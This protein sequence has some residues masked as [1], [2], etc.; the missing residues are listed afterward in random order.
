MQG[1]TTRKPNYNWLKTEQDRGSTDMNLEHHLSYEAKD[2]MQTIF[3]I[4][5]I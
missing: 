4:L 2:F 1:T 5:D 3:G